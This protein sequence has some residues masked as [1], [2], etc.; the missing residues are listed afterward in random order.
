MSADPAPV[1]VLAAGNPSRGDDAIGHMLAERLDAAGFP[2]VEV[3]T[4]F[5]WQV[6]HALELEGRA[7]AVFVDAG[8]ATAAPFE[9]RAVV[10]SARYLHTTH[11]LEP[12]AVIETYRRVTGSTPPPALLLC[13]RGESFELGHALTPAAITHLEAAWARLRRLCESEWVRFTSNR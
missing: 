10:A 13:V 3:L 6:E 2:D 4:D 5:Q 1:L 7:L 11:A 8:M 12:G 9:L